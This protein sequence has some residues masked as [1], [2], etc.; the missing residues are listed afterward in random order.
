MKESKQAA[1]VNAGRVSS[2]GWDFSSLSHKVFLIL[3]SIV[4]GHWKHLNGHGSSGRLISITAVIH[5][6][7]CQTETGET[8][9]IRHLFWRLI[10]HPNAFSYISN[11]V[12]LWTIAFFE[13]TDAN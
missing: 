4:N 6:F 5:Q 2:W 10:H 12:L 11:A 8:K 13:R 3:S 1:T 7:A 9:D